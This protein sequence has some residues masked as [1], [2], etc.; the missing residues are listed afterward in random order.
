MKFKQYAQDFVDEQTDYEM[1]WQKAFLF[2]LFDSF[3]IG[4]KYGFTLIFFIFFW[5]VFN[6]KIITEFANS[7]CPVIK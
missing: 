4:L 2:S 5:S 1:N 3:F 6:G 7:V